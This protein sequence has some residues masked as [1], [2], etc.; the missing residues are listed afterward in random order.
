M[1]TMQ[2]RGHLRQADLILNAQSGGFPREGR[3]DRGHTPKQL[4]PDV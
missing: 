3:R 2:E 4:R 1:G